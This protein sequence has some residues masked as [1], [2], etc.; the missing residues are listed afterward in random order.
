MVGTTS[1]SQ[2]HQLLQSCLTMQQNLVSLGMRMAVTV[3]KQTYREDNNGNDTSDSNH[4][5]GLFPIPSVRLFVLQQM[6][7]ETLTASH[8][9]SWSVHCSSTCPSNYEAQD[10]SLHLRFIA[11]R[12]LSLQKTAFLQAR[13]KTEL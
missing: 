10:C 11:N 9:C 7:L 3:R 5:L 2:Q 6:K 8:P 4:W 1:I 12:R 13:P